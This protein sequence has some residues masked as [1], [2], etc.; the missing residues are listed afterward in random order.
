LVNVALGSANHD[1]AAFAE[2]E[3]FDITRAGPRHLAFGMG[4]HYCLGAPLAR[5][6]ASIAIPALFAH[7]P[8]LR[9]LD[10]EPRWRDTIGFR[11]LARLD[12]AW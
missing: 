9:L 2:P 4:M 3:R 6:E 8:H 7:F 5:Q 11:G 10:P 1:P 12:T